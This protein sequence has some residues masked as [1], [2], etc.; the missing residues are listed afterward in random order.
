MGR[1]S[2]RWPAERVCRGTRSR[3]GRRRRA[4]GECPRAATRASGDRRACRVAAGGAGDRCPPAT[5][6]SAHGDRHRA[7]LQA[8]RAAV[9]PVPAWPGGPFTDD[10]RATGSPG[11]PC[12]V[13]TSASP[14]PHVRV[15]PSR[16]SG[17]GRQ[18]GHSSAL[19]PV[20]LALA[21]SMVRRSRRHSVRSACAPRRRFAKARILREPGDPSPGEQR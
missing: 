17:G 6:R 1:R 20:P 10:R 4:R 12:R 19:H 21:P 16:G 9:T 13:A 5:Q 3:P 7:C 14:M 8:A 11:S 15:Q 2:A 18:C